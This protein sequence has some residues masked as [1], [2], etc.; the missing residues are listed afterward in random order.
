LSTIA[1]AE[2]LILIRP[3]TSSRNFFNSTF[4]PYFVAKS[5]LLKELFQLIKK[6]IKEHLD[7]K[8]YLSIAGFLTLTTTLNYILNFE[9][10][11]IDPYQGTIWKGVFMFFF[12][13][14]P[15]LT[16][17][18][19][20]Y[21][22]NKN[23]TWIRSTEFW[24][25]ILFG[26]SVLAFYRSFPVFD[27][28]MGQVLD[29]ADLYFLLAPIQ[30]LTGLISVVIPLFAFYYLFEQE[31]DK[32]YYGLKLTGFDPKPYLILLGIGGLFILLGSFETNVNE[33]YP[34]YN[35]D[36]GQAFAVHHGW[37]EWVSVGIWE[38]FYGIR[39]VYVELFFRGF[40]IMSLSRILGGH[41][42]LPMVATYMFL[43]YGKPL[44]ESISSVFGGYILGIISLY[45]RKI[46]GV[47]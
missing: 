15:F 34:K 11:Y 12:H 2:A 44:A 1:F 24:Y 33:F 35:P 30:R 23:R 46:W 37:D 13:S 9:D 39:F 18:L 17:C 20:L 43:H 45:T 14:F 29:P 26:F 47:S 42:V 19:L 32:A 31:N 27:Q 8:L 28:W 5:F 4:Y 38:S 10:D 40:L 22:F 7:W 16:V 3:L 36:L 6:Y 21:F 25:K 41:V